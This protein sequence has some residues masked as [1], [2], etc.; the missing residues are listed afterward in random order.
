MAVLLG[1]LPL[2]AT[3]SQLIT[4]NLFMAV[5]LFEQL[6]TIIIVA[7]A[8]I[9]LIILL[10]IKTQFA[11]ILTANFISLIMNSTVISY[12]HCYLKLGYSLQLFIT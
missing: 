10:G 4:I 1:P 5:T 11:S 8:I 2:L 3:Q 6:I 9:D 12:L 7:V